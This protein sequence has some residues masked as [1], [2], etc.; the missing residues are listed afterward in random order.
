VFCMATANK[1]PIVGLLCLDCDGTL[2]NS[3]QAVSS[4]N[5][6]AVAA[7]H[8]AGFAIVLCTG[9]SINCNLPTARSLDVEKLY[10]VGCNGTVVCS[11]AEDSR[12]ADEV[13]F[14]TRLSSAQVDRLANG[15]GHGR[16]L[17]AYVGNRQLVQYTGP[18]Q[19]SLVESH[20][21]IEQTS[22]DRVDDLRATLAGL[23]QAPNKI[24]V[25]D[26]SD[27]HTLAAEARALGVSEGIAM[28]TGGP[29]WVDSVHVEHD[30]A[31]G[32][33]LLCERL[34]V[35]LADC[36]AFG[37]G[38]N[39]ASM[40]SACGLGIAMAQGK[41]EA[42]A[43]ANRVSQWTNEEDAVAKELLAVLAEQE[44]LL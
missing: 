11:L 39:D 34:S 18:Q 12:S 40:L 41:D 37:D 20:N 38:A 13:F 23:D 10:L 15:I 33:A 6:Q 19:Q 35:S 22:P 16:A 30:K 31:V 21:A 25:L 5:A 43:A 14:E 26:D 1:P 3:A 7:A 42:K 36:I 32:V 29:Y 44:R 8:R 4:T 2:Y 17:K 24:T 28:L 9:R 27:G